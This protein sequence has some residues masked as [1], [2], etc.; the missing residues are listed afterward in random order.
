MRPS[1][2]MFAYF[3]GISV[4]D[5]VREETFNRYSDGDTDYGNTENNIT[6]HPEGATVLTSD[7]NGAIEGSFFLP[8]TSTLKFPFPLHHL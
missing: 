3:D 4:A 1:S 6:A 7:V 2:S 8:N 5:F